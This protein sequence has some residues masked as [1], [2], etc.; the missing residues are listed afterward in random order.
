MQELLNQQHQAPESTTSSNE[1][2]IDTMRKQLSDKESQLTSRFDGLTRRER[3]LLQRENDLKTKYAGVQSY[4]EMKEMASK[5]PLKVMEKLGLSYDKLTDLY[6][7]MSP[8]DET[9]K[10]VGS[11]KS[12]IEDLKTRLEQDAAQGQMKEVM[13]VKGA[14]LTTLK[15]LASKEDSDYSLVAHFGVYDDVLNY[16]AKHYESSGEILDDDEALRHVEE[17]LFENLKSL[18]SNRKIQELMGAVEH[19]TQGQKPDSP[20][21]LSDSKFKN[22]TPKTETTRGLSDAQLFEIALSKMPDI[23]I[24]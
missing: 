11:L 24:R 22:E 16:M 18:K 14:K 17:R 4:E 20:F 23:K 10:T 7:G 5:D 2:D 21:S 15:N 1:P 12:E 8:K 19:G 9:E 6:A 13:R 3:M